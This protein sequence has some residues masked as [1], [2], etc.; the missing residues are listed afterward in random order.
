MGVN[1][2]SSDIAR[3]LP[4]PCCAMPRDSSL[5][6]HVQRLDSAEMA[7]AMHTNP[8][9][10]QFT[11][12][13]A[14]E[15]ESEEDVH[16]LRHA[17]MAADVAAAAVSHDGF[18]AGEQPLLQLLRRCRQGVDANVADAAASVAAG[19]RNVAGS[20]D[21]SGGGGGSGGHGKWRSPWA[22]PLGL[23]LQTLAALLR[24]A[25]GGSP[26]DVSAA[27]AAEALAAAQSLLAHEALP[28]SLARGGDVT[29]AILVPLHLGQTASAQQRRLLRSLADSLAAAAAAVPARDY[30]AWMPEPTVALFRLCRLTG[31]ASNACKAAGGGGAALW[32]VGSEVWQP[33]SQAAASALSVVATGLR[34][35]GV[36]PEDQD[37]LFAAAYNVARA[38]VD[39]LKVGACVCKA[40]ASAWQPQNAGLFTAFPPQKA[41]A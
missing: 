13:F 20:I 12:R 15:C 32:A 25:G 14:L 26:A 41:F 2:F 36:S 21:S 35:D 7:V 22:P 1:E 19:G 38:V 4:T 34:A 10:S 16:A 3:E 39:A 27:A 24:R 8:T 18:S 11:C 17:T 31:R 29:S 33:W 30:T 40:N 23:A 28:L 6:L 37:L 9:G 5:I